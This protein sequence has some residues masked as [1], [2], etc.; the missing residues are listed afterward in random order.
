M[1][2]I[3]LRG[4]GARVWAALLLWAAEAALRCQ[5]SSQEKNRTQRAPHPLQNQPEILLQ[6]WTGCSAELSW[7][8][9]EL[10]SN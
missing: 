9:Q 7:E 10:R 8:L 6:L 2:T 3:S 5:G 1:K 4:L